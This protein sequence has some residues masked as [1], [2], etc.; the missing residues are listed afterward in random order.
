MNIIRF[1]EVLSV[2]EAVAD[3]E[4]LIAVIMFDASEAIVSHLDEA[5][6]HYILLNKAG[7]RGTDIDKY[8][9]VIF[10]K[11]GADWTFVCPPDYKNIA[12]KTRRIAQFYKDGFKVITEFLKEFGFAGS[13]INV[14]KR[15]RR[16]INF[17]SEN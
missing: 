7:R 15:Y 13:E 8:Y 17:M 10:D 6:E 4:P 16:H 11:D 3:N 2:A 14:P 1:E 12:D 9:R 5:A